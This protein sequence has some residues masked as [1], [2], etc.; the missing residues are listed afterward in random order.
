MSTCR[1]HG[2]SWLSAVATAGYGHADLPAVGPEYGS[3]QRRRPSRPRCT[4]HSLRTSAERPDWPK[5]FSW[6]VSGQTVTVTNKT[7][8]H[9][10][11][12]ELD[13]HVRFPRPSDLSH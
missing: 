7:S 11:P 13:R 3:L 1:D 8:V 10:H 12:A 5:D 9:G 2:P 4:L 6:T